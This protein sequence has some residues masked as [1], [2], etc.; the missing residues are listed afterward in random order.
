MTPTTYTCQKCGYRWTPRPGRL[1]QSRDKPVKCA[2][3]SCQS[4]S[5]DKKGD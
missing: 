1:E 4:V 2:N 5:W 3:V